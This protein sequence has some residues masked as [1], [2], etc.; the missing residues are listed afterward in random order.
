MNRCRR[1]AKALA[2]A[3]GFIVIDAALDSSVAQAGGLYF[4]DR[5]VKPLSRGGAWIAGADDIG[6]IWYN[7]AGLADAGTSLMVDFAWLNHRSEFTRKTQV[8]DAAGTVRVYE[9]PTVEGK[10]PILPIPTIGGS[11]NF[12]QR[13]EFTLAGAVYAPYTALSSFPTVVDGQPAPQRYS[14]ISLD[15]S[16][17]VGIGAWF[18]YKPIEQIRLGIGVGALVGAFTSTIFFNANPADRLIGA[19]EDP[20]YDAQGQLKANIISPTANVGA[21]FVPDKHVR[22]GVSYNLPIWVNAPGSLKVRLPSAVLFDKAS[23]SGD[24]VKVKFKLPGIFRVGVEVRPIEALRAEVAYVREF[25]GI[26]DRIDV[27]PENVALNNVTG[28]PSPYNVPS[29]TLPRGFQDSNSFRVG[30]QY[31]VQIKEKYKIDFRAGFN[32]DQS[33]VPA[34]YLSALTID[35]DK[36]TASLGGSLHVG[37]HWRLDAVYARIFAKD[38]EVSPAEAA[39]PRVN[40]VRGNPTATESINGGTYSASANVFGVGVNYKF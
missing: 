33:A 40:P 2:L 4:S 32:Y 34:P 8:V 26:H 36:Y 22:I 11:Y 25:W 13:K 16:A 19:P 6:A 21:T 12:G 28:F 35:L 15:G 10:S 20:N 27:Y 31:T 30:A 5:G 1:A 39:V 18:A 3:V 7:P 17:L 9:F 14:L 37:N 29:I 38:Q 24:D 23:V